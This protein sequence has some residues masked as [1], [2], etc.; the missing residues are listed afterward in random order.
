MRIL[1]AHSLLL[2]NEQTWHGKSLQWLMS[3]LA[4]SALQM[5]LSWHTLKKSLCKSSS[6]HHLDSAHTSWPQGRSRAAPVMQ[7]FYS[8]VIFISLGCQYPVTFQQPKNYLFLGT[9]FW[10]GNLSSTFAWFNFSDSL[11]VC[12]GPDHLQVLKNHFPPCIW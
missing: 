12:L 5:Y 6:H 9:S 11:F 8:E 2:C 4:R 7:N 10:T 1:V 3:W